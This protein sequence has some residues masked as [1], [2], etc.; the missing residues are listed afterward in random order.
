[1]DRICRRQYDARAAQASG[2]VVEKGARLKSLQDALQ[3]SG[4][5]ENVP[6]VSD[7]PPKTPTVTTGPSV[8]KLPVETQVSY[9]PVTASA[10]L[11]FQL[12]EDPRIVKYSEKNAVCV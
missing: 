8:T 6:E 7:T 11:S 9:T 5:P 1:M 12:Q 3:I 4:T 10:I 2:I